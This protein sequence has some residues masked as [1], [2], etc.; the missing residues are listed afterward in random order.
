MRPG[1]PNQST[2]PPPAVRGALPGE[3]G[4]QAGPEA[5]VV[6]QG[7]QRAGGIA[8]PL[9]QERREG[10]VHPLRALGAP[11]LLRL[12]HLTRTG[13]V[14]AGWAPGRSW[15]PSL[16]AAARPWRA[17]QLCPRA[18][19]TRLGREALLQPPLQG[20][21]PHGPGR[22]PLLRAAKVEHVTAQG[23]EGPEARGLHPTPSL[24]AGRSS[25]TSAEPTI[26]HLP[27]CPRPPRPP[28][29]R[30]LQNINETRACYQ[31]ATGLS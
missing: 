14:R 10:R 19:E 2:A 24:A 18:P 12:E 3:G 31:S 9:V 27:R 13:R 15:H 28:P 11:K 26:D 22:L 8:V 20:S 4:V 5:V 21:P 25:R 1:P 29:G 17:Q 7:G 16:E 23:K 6:G 30:R